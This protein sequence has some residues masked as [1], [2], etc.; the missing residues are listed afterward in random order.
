MFKDIIIKEVRKSNVCL[1]NKRESFISMQTEL[2]K[3][4]S[5]KHF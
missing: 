4:K 3:I 1:K 2:C 5:Q